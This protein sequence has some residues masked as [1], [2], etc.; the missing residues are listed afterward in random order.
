MS[1]FIS[2]EDFISLKER[3]T[4]Y[5]WDHYPMLRFEID[6]LVA[7]TISDLW[8]YLSRR[9]INETLSNIEIV[10]IAFAIFNR[11]VVDT[12]RKFAAQ[13]ASNS[14]AVSENEQIDAST[15]DPIYLELYRRMLLI[16][17][18]ELANVSEEDHLLLAG[19]IGVGLNNSETMVPADRQRLHRL[20]KRLTAAIVRELGDEASNLLRE[21]I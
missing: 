9:P 7:H 21:D 1:D 13:W 17:I 11:R 5:G 8:H 4:R 10:K 16:C 6:D 18:S 12:H 15:P 19:V 2:K 20:R 3:L 14:G